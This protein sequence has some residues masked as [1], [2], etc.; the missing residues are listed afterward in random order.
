MTLN[1]LVPN[2][3][4]VG[5]GS[6]AF[7]T[8][9]S[10]THKVWRHGV[11]M[12]G[13]IEVPRGY[14]NIAWQIIQHLTFTVVASGTNKTVT[15]TFSFNEAI[16]SHNVYALR[17]TATK[18]GY[19]DLDWIAPAEFTVLP[20]KFTEGTADLVIDVSTGLGNK[21]G[22]NTD[23][24][25]SG[26]YKIWLKGTGTST[27]LNALNF[28]SW[29][30]SDPTKPTH[31]GGNCTITCNNRAL[32]WS[33]VK[34]WVFDGCMD[35]NEPHG[36]KLI[37]SSG[38]GGSQENMYM[39][40][41]ADYNWMYCGIDID[42][43]DNTYGVSAACVIQNSAADSTQ[44]T[45]LVGFNI[46]VNRSAA[47]SCYKGHTDDISG[48]ATNRYCLYYRCN[49]TNANNEGFQVGIHEDTEIFDCTWTN[50]AL[51]GVAGQINST[52]STSGNKN[53]TWFRNRSINTQAIYF[54]HT[55][56]SQDTIE[57]FA[58]F[59]ETTGT[60]ENWSIRMEKSSG[61]YLYF[62]FFNNTIR[63]STSQTFKLYKGPGSPTTI[64]NP[65]Y[66][67]SNIVMSSTVSPEYTLINGLDGTFLTMNNYATTTPASVGF[68]DL[69]NKD[70]RL[71]SLSSPAFSFSRTTVTGT[72]LHPWANYDYYGYKYPA[73]N[74]AAGADSGFLLQAG[75]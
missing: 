51:S 17:V 4:Y 68:V 60:G 22:N 71:A 66:F 61:T 6:R 18:A 52:Q 75:L 53:L 57:Q 40:P 42:N 73:T 33:G 70:Y 2:P 69:A 45:G 23:R 29:Y 56:I 36:I 38:G 7:F 65:F 46:N 34:N 74:I 25:A 62:G 31:V 9:P 44:N 15:N 8:N 58:N 1:Y 47:E 49:S 11:A 50:D 21:N 35:E 5:V 67:S 59:M 12:T 14:I 55:G 48:Y 30:S 39:T 20:A 27:S 54:N 16:Y 26:G 32:A 19:P 10:P 37:K 43:V 72:R 64:F 63:T 3:D 41:V 24:A 13:R 28:F